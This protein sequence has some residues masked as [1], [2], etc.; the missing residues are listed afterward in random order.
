MV[1]KYIT[2][3]EAYLLYEQH[4]W[5]EYLPFESDMEED[6][7]GHLNDTGVEVIDNEEFQIY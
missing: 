7:I 1:M 6:F 2:R 4:G 3:E 5:Y